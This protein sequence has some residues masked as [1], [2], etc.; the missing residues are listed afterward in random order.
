MHRTTLDEIQSIVGFDRWKH[1]G[2]I[3]TNV[4]THEDA[5]YARSAG[6]Q[7]P[8]GNHFRKPETAANPHCSNQPHRVPAF[9]LLQAVC[10][11]DLDWNAI[12]ELI[13]SDATIYYDSCASLIPLELEFDVKSVR[14]AKRLGCSAMMRIRRWCRLSGM[15]EMSQGRPSDLLLSALV[16]ARFA[17]LLGQRIGHGGADLFLLGLLTLMDTILEIPMSAIIDGLSLDEVSTTFLL[18]HE[19]GLRP[20]FELVFAVETGAWD[21]VLQSCQLLHVQEEFAAQCYSSA[22]AWA[23][24]LTDSI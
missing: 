16:R 17:E 1:S 4:E 3:A 9:V 20:V 14:C 23:Q 13:K 24:V 5:E 19:G 11:P 2:L 12:E 10:Q 18:E 15:F 8:Q 21:S 22:M 7:F 6:F